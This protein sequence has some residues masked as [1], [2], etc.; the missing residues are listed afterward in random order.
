MNEKEQ[1]ASQREDML[2]HIELLESKHFDQPTQLLHSYKLKFLEDEVARLRKEL[3]KS[4]SAREG[5]LLRQVERMMEE[6]YGL[7]KEL[8]AALV[9]KESLTRQL[10]ELDQE[11]EEVRVGAHQKVI[12]SV[13]YIE[14]RERYKMVLVECKELK[15]EMEHI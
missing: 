14:L 4:K 2:Q 1:L 8:R 6:K 13:E 5:E 11:L 10:E 12:R 9:G 3:A 7:E 15:E